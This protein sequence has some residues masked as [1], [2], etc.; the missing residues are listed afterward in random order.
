MVMRPLIRPIDVL[1]YDNQNLK[2]RLRIQIN[3]CSMLIVLDMAKT[4][5]FSV[6]CPDEVE[7]KVEDYLV[8][9]R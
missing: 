8:V 5:I 1:I 9:T 7:N 2:I 3:G 4:P 6:K